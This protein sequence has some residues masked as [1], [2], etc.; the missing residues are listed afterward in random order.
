MV[1]LTWKLSCQ[2][3]KLVNLMYG[4]TEPWIDLLSTHQ[5]C[6]Y[7]K[8]NIFCGISFQTFN[9]VIFQNETVGKNYIER[10]SVRLLVFPSI[11]LHWAQPQNHAFGTSTIMD[12]RRKY[13]QHII[14]NCL[15]FFLVLIPIYFNTK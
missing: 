1:S 14:P 9:G 11:T 13:Q 7:F 3:V 15:F 12:H 6:F 10:K 8:L 5:F 4:S 2:N